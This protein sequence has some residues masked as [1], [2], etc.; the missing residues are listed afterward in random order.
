MDDPNIEILLVEDNPKDV[1]LTLH[2]LKRNNLANRVHVARD[3]Q[4]VLDLFFGPAANGQPPKPK[5]V[6]LDLKLPKVHGLEV[7]RRLKGDP[8]TKA[9]P[10]VVMTSSTMETDMVESYDLGANSYLRKPVDFNEFVA[11][12]KTLGLYWLLLNKMPP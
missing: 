4:E 5:L 10:V 1:E 11:C 9:I 2:A 6:L 7:L 8:R 12:A 3:G